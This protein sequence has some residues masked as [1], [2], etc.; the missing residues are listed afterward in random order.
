MCSAVPS[1]HLTPDLW[2][3]AY[4]KACQ[5]PCSDCRFSQLRGNLLLRATPG[6]GGQQ[7]SAVVKS[8]ELVSHWI[9]HSYLTEVLSFFFGVLGQGFFQPLVIHW[10]CNCASWVYALE[11]CSLDLFK[12]EQKMDT[13]KRWIK[14]FYSQK[15]EQNSL[16]SV[17]D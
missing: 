14:F 8:K 17:R 4:S 9:P 13:G 6:I 7:Q 3:S 2:S 11:L 10:D 1:V 5:Q 12:P 16:V 15:E